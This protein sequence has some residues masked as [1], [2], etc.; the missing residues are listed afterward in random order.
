MIFEWDPEKDAANQAKHGLPLRRGELG[1]EDPEKLV[2]EDRRMDYG[3][4]R[5]IVLAEI[6]G[7]VHVIVYTPRGDTIR[8]ISVRKANEREQR[9]YHDG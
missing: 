4:P 6:E 5:F 7:R 1:F 8:L 9:L 3:E 2:I